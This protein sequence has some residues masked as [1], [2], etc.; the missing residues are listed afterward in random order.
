MILSNYAIKF[1]VAVLVFVVVLAIAGTVSYVTLPREGTPDITIPYVFVS[2]YYEGTAPEEME[3]LVT[4]PLEKQLKDVEGVKEIRS[5]SAENIGSIVI[6]FLAGEDIERAR[7]RVKDK[8]DLAKP[9]LPA[10]LDEPIVDAFNFSSD[11]PVYIFALSGV[12]DLDRLK[13][14]AEDLQD[15]LEQLP[16]I[17]SADIAGTREREIRV[18]IDL[19]RMIAYRL[20]LGQV[21]NR[22]AQENVTLSAGNI[23]MAG[24][25]FQVRIP[26]EFQRVPEL[27]DILVAERDGRPVYLSDIAAVTDT[28]KDLTSISRLNGQPCISINLKKRVGVNAV[29]LI[30]EVK[31][32]LAGARLPP[33]VKLTEV[34]DMSDYIAS[35]IEEL[36]NN[37][38]S[39]F[40]LVVA[41]LLIFLGVRNALFVGLAIPLSMLIGF[42]LMAARGTTLN[43]IVLFSLVLAVG[44]LVDN[45]IVIVENTYRLRTLGLPRTEAARRGASEVAWPVITSTL[46]TLVAFWPLLFWP[47]IMGQFMG[48]LPRTL[49]VVLS[50]SLF[51][52]M[53][54]NPAI[55]SFFI[56]ARPRDAKEKVHW[57]VA[58]YE[59]LLRA[60]LRHRV[61]V[62]LLGFAFLILSVQAYA[63][64]GRGIEL[65]PDVEPRNATVQIKFP[66]GTSIERTDAALRAI[67][68]KLP[69]YPDIKFYLTTIGAQSAM[70]FGGGVAA[71]HQG[72]I[73]VEFVDAADRQTNSLAL[74]DA[75]RKDAGV[76]P[77]AELTVEREEEGPPT[78]APVSIEL[79]GDDFELLEQFAGDILRAIETVP[80]LVDLQSDLEKALPEVQFHVDRARAALLGLDTATIGQFLRMSIYGLESS[81]FRADEDEYDITLR[82]PVDQRNTMALL[83]QAFIPVPGGTTVPL[84]SL[85]R[86]EYAGGR[87]A[88]QRKQQKRVVTITGNNQDRGVDKI[89]KDVQARI[90]EIPLPRG[91]S[92][93][94]TGDTQEM[95]DSGIFL[96]K[97]FG[98]ASGLILVILVIQF[99][100]ILLPLII[101]FSV[102]LS[103]IGVMWGLLACHM[104]FGVV[105]TGVGVISL[106]GIVVNNAI[107][108]IDCALKRREE[109]L[110][111]RE[112]IVTAG[113]LRLRPVLLTASTTVLGLIPMAIGYSLEIH[114]W[115]PRIIAGAESSAWWAPMAV[116]VL[117]GLTVATVLTLVLVPAMFSLAED[118]AAVIRRRFKPHD[119]PA[120]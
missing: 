36:E 93:S 4:I 94:Y 104:R 75:I 90:A 43:M 66:Q 13:N 78:G 5:T 49:I 34:M 17:K 47:G 58:N 23:E 21:M 37:V 119:E 118:L 55:C 86:L 68:E 113:R 115:P 15:Q 72:T 91:F 98:I 1:R 35:M 87:G 73:Y 42:T 99:N 69:A 20:P 2:A 56:Q 50:S 12:P 6:E 109:G 29:S 10:D 63:R 120:A 22:I 48:F 111:S 108:L 112:A 102:I 18:E 53:V 103:M 25:K 76:V 26:G 65:F 57:F 110:D 96:L 101:F 71:T 28:F 9:D 105:M 80:G 61:P 67:E 30:R 92:V 11:F 62:L 82:L 24:D 97:A 79:S 83:S 77:G 27:R 8:V 41:V 70:S 39:G 46:T 45:A 116:A 31:R 44:M 107:V 100:S 54:I 33:D 52:A 32:I 106:A 117:F 88:I 19:P 3:K 14:L 81:K 84:T 59:R 89:L 51:V 40:L 114:H 38:V 85:G 64:W 60:A 74:I 7:Q 16:G 95:R